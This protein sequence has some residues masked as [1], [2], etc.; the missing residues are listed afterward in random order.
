MP[1]HG[2]TLPRNLRVV[3]SWLDSGSVAVGT[4]GTTAGLGSIARLTEVPLEFGY[5]RN[6]YLSQW[7]S[8]HLLLESLDLVH[9]TCCKL[10]C[11][12][13]KLSVLSLVEAGEWMFRDFKNLLY[14][15]F[16]ASF[17]IVQAYLM[18]AMFTPE[19][20]VLTTDV[21]RVHFLVT[22][23]MAKCALVLVF[24]LV[25]VTW[26]KHH[27]FLGELFNRALSDEGGCV[28]HVLKDQVYGAVKLHFFIGCLVGGQ[29]LPCQ[30]FRAS[31][32]I[33][34]ALLSCSIL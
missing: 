34:C 25:C 8:A 5:L 11:W 17:L 16:E 18:S 4:R 33:T 12:F 31:S 27:L 28:S 6:G 19:F 9:G 13:E 1:A 3:W 24:L 22:F 29:R 23:T 10:Y 30:I 26:C 15:S 2:G 32:P 20:L 14:A 21:L 7:P